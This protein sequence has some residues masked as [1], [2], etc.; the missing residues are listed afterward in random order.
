MA[1]L[2]ILPECVFFALS[3]HYAAVAATVPE[4]PLTFHQTTT[5]SW[6][7]SGGSERKDSSRLCSST[8]AIASRRLAM[9]SSRDLP[10]PLAPGISA[11]YATYHG[12]HARQSL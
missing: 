6:R 10:C 12:R 3:A 8:S 9:H 4:Q 11:Q 7:A 5:T 2:R 1:G